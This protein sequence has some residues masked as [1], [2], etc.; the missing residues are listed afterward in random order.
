MCKLDKF[1][2]ELKQAPKQWHETF[3]NLMISN[4][5]KVNESDKCV[6]Y[7]FENNICTIICLYVDELL[8]FWSN[9][10]AVIDVKSS[11]CKKFNMKCLK[12]V[13]VILGIKITWY[14]RGISLDYSHYMEKILNK[15]NYSGCIPTCIS[16][17]QSVKLSKNTSDRLGQK[18]M[19]TSLVVMGMSLIVLNPILHM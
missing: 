2:Y 10:H 16:Y 4:G 7:K 9:L 6:Y 13:S 11:F 3:D 17:D 14:E 19:R 5:Y 12:E 18:S 1:L 15:N 8:K